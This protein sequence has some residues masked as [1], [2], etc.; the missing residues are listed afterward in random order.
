MRFY[1][2]ID[3][4]ENQVTKP[5]AANKIANGWAALSGNRRGK[6]VYARPPKLFFLDLTSGKEKEIPNVI[7]GGGPGIMWFTMMIPIFMSPLL[8]IPAKALKYQQDKAAGP[9]S[10][11]PIMTLTDSK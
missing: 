2:G 11:R 6:V 8:A 4:K 5:P 1:E 10:T 9:T 3:I 7:T